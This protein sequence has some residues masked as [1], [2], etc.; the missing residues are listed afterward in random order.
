MAINPYLVLS[1]PI[2]L[3]FGYTFYVCYQDNQYLKRRQKAFL[4]F[5][6]STNRI[7]AKR[8]SKPTTR[9]D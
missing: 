7:L 2:V 4:G 9:K 5:A 1:T 6:A 3:V 8:A